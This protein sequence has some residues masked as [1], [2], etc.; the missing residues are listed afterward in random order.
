MPANNTSSFA[1]RLSARKSTHDTDFQSEYIRL[2][3]KKEQSG[4]RLT[5]SEERKL[6]KFRNIDKDTQLEREREFLERKNRKIEELKQK[7]E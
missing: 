7:K 6:D 3:E 2:L 4:A 1:N 5:A